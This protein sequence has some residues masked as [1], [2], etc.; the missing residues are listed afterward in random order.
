M[1]NNPPNQINNTQ[2]ALDA[3]KYIAESAKIVE[4]GGMPTT[5]MHKDMILKAHEELL[6]NPLRTKQIV[7]LET[8]VS[9]IE[10]FNKFADDKSAIF[11]N[12]DSAQF[13]GV[14]DYHTETK[15]AWLEHLV[16]FECKKTKEWRTWSENDKIKM[17][18]TEFA[19]FIEDNSKE[20]SDPA[21][22]TMMEIALTLKAKKNI[23]FSSGIQLQNGQVQLSYVEK[24]D[25]SAGPKGEIQ[26]PDKFKLGIRIFEGGDA[27]A[28]E[29]HFRYRL[30]DGSIK[31][32]YELIRAHKVHESAVEDVFVKVKK[33]TKC[34]LIVH[35]DFLHSR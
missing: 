19:Y 2:S 4:V 32:W 24:I 1:D 11:C 26:I 7:K 9:F 23:N 15:A 31:M 29:A 30:Y 16:K 25:G 18:Q 20:F 28:I 22:S 8:P 17:D 12:V 35:G 10:Y 6:E 34:Q 13:T 3:G 27:Y 5:I 14:I 33:D 21:G